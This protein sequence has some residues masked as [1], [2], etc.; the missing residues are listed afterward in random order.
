MKRK[1]LLR[2]VKSMLVLMMAIGLLNGCTK[3]GDTPT[4]PDPIPIETNSYAM[5]VVEGVQLSGSQLYALV[6]IEN[7]TG[8]PVVV[9]K[10]VTLDFISGV[11]KTDKIALPIGSHRLTKMVIVNA[12]DSA[13]YAAPKAGTA[14]A[15]LVSGPLP[16]PVNIPEKGIHY[17]STTVLKIASNDAPSAYGYTSADFGYHSSIDLKVSLT[18]S[19]GQIVYSNIPGMLKIDAVNAQGEHWIREVSL[20]RG[21]NSIHVP[22]GFTQYGFSIVKW[23]KQIQ[24]QF[25]RANLQPGMQINFSAT[26]VFKK[27]KEEK[28]YTETASGYT[29][30]SRTEYTYDIAGRLLLIKN[31]QRSTQVSGLPLNNT[32]TFQYLNNKVD[33]IKFTGADNTPNGYTAF[34]YL[35]E[36][37]RQ[38]SYK[39]YDQETH[40]VFEYSFTGYNHNIHG[41]YLF[42]NGLSMSYD[43]VFENGN[44]VSDLVQSSNG[45]SELGQ[46]SY[47]DNINPYHLIGYQDLYLSNASQSNLLSQ[48]KS[49]SG[50]YPTSVPYKFEYVYDED[51]YPVAVY[52]SFRGYLSNNHLFR[53]KKEFFYY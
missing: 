10:K 52:T 2:K 47:D 21:E 18:M 23:N 22:D 19:L 35:G 39:R 41:T 43:F 17:Y 36:R 1:M 11:F 46:Y 7:A 33:T 9:N 42:H 44:K 26:G 6:S 34:T 37:I 15:G 32:S 20:T 48:Q 12:A 4:V 8:S 27:L 14:K 5:F 40:G 30:D 31:Y 50:A 13:V 49:Y 3:T 51:G 24:Q 25:S 29:P 16:I 28:V 45:G 38:V 53:L